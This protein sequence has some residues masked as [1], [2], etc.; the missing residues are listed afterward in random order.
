MQAQGGKG[1]VDDGGDLGLVGDVQRA[2]ADDVDVGLIELPVA[3]LLGPLPTVDL[4]DLEPAEGEGQLVLVE[5][6]DRS[7]S[8][9]VKR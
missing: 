8:P 9:L 1:L 4:A 7:L 5:G 6:Q 3:A 2:V